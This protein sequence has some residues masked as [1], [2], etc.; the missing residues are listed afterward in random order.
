MSFSLLKRSSKLSVKEQFEFVKI[1]VPKGTEPGTEI[2]I[3][4]KDGRVV[5]I[6]TPEKKFR[7]LKVSAIK[8]ETQIII[9]TI[10]TFNT[11]K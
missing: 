1:K 11:P 6:V 10:Y 7:S 2:I 9:F 8:Y 4:M 5:K 3:K